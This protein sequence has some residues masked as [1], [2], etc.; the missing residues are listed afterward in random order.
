M[1]GPEYINTQAAL[2]NLIKFYC[3]FV[4]VRM[5]CVCMFRDYNN[6]EKEVTDLIRN[7]EGHLGRVSGC[8]ESRERMYLYFNF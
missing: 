5:Y 6:L 8:G 7:N 1:F 3:I 2:N 4:C